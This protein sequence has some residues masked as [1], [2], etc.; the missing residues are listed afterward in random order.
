MIAVRYFPVFALQK[1]KFNRVGG[2]TKIKIRQDAQ[3][4]PPLPPHREFASHENDFPIARFPFAA[5]ARCRGALL[6]HVLR[7]RDDWVA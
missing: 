5:P 3:T 4:I 1:T 2:P 6:H 7:M